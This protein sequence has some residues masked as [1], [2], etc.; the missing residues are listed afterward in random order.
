M[1]VPKFVTQHFRYHDNFE[2]MKEDIRNGFPQDEIWYWNVVYA[3]DLVSDFETLGF[4]QHEF[5][6]LVEYFESWKQKEKKQIA[7]DKY[8]GKM[9]NRDKAIEALLDYYNAIYMRFMKK[10][11]LE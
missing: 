1:N 11:K 8:D 5:L 7:L 3:V 2:A 6:N 9:T 10:V 4:E